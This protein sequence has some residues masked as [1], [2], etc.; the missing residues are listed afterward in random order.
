MAAMCNLYSMTRNQ[1]AIRWL[2][3]LRRDNTGNLPPLPA[4]YPDG[5][6]PVVRTGGDGARE[7]IMMRWGFPPPPNPERVQQKWTPVLRLDTRHN[8]RPEPDD[9][10][11]KSHPALRGAP[12]TN[13]RNTGSLYW[14]AWL[15][16]GFRCLVPATSFCE[17]TDNRPKVAHWFALAEDRPLFAFAGL[18]RPWTGT[19]GSK[20][21]PVTGEH[22]LFSVVTTEANE[23]VRPVHAKAM[24]VVLTTEAEW[25][26]WLEAPTV[27]ALALQRPL[28]VDKLKIVA[29]G[30]R[31]DEVIGA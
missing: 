31:T 27:Q 10:S 4:I 8:N 14:R 28:T 13:I 30:T 11:Q 25:Q 15:A 17:W 21:A 22:L 2:F 26:T 7:L 23:T 20:A 1:D 12:V 3:R 18:W 9:D 5:L 6:A 16:Q 29:T 24:P 19:R